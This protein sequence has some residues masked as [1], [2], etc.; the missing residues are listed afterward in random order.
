MTIN[1]RLTVAGIEDEYYRLYAAGEFDALNRL[2]ATV[3]LRIDA[4]GMHWSL[5][6]DEGPQSTNA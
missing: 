3:Q 1:E 5:D 4:N 6:D 2:L